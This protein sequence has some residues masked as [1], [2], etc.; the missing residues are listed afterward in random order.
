MLM[1]K[2]KDDHQQQLNSTKLYVSNIPVESDHRSI[3]AYFSRFGRVLQCS[4]VIRNTKYAFIHYATQAEVE[5]V[6]RNANRMFLM[7]HK[8]TIKL[9]RTPTSSNYNP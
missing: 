6:L 4:V 5:N 2:M 8:L 3:T 1:I 9:S 7:G